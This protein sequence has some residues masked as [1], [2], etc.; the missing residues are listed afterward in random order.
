MQ[1]GGAR[2]RRRRAGWLP[3]FASGCALLAALGAAGCA[4]SEPKIPRLSDL[5]PFAE[6]EVPLPGKRIP[7]S[8]TEGRAG[9]DVA[10]ADRPIVLPPAQ[11]NPTWS[12]PGGTPYNSS[13]HMALGASL[14]Q[15]WSAD[16]GAGS[17]GYGKLTASPIVV[18][19]RIYVLDTRGR[20]T[21]FSQSGSTVWRVSVTPPTEKDYNGYGGG[22]A[23][24]G[25]RIFVATGYGWIVAL[26]AQ[27]GKKLWEKNLASP[28]R[29]SPTAADGRVFVVSADGIARALAAAD[30]TELW[31]HQGLIE[32]AA[33]LTNASPAAAGDLVVVPYPSGEVVALRI[34]D[35]QPA[36]TESLARTR[37]ASS[38]GSMTDAARPVVDGGAVFAVGHSGRM[39]AT[40]FRDG[41]RLWS[42]SVPGIQAPAVAGDNLF[43]VDTSGQLMAV[44][45]AD[46]K[47]IWTTKLPGTHTWSGP[48]LAGNRLWLTSNKGQL[49]GADATT[50]K[51][52]VQLKLSGPS[53]IAPIVAGGRLYVLTDSARLIAFQ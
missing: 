26:D 20:V 1:S 14:R 41:Q 8:L 35:G 34:A 27:S 44:T 51:V 49:V 25:G 5:N 15:A 12:Q 10:P 48:V 31:T 37:V 30:G 45:R 7:V 22:L 28:V 46:G 17:S 43:V 11:P 19:G 39:V 40:T 24:D 4:G 42:L 47:I 3:V 21:A 33:L 9:L 36:W 13:G 32:K 29:S 38:L 2:T 16:A 18:D 50:G 53:Y 23:S 52:D 6:K